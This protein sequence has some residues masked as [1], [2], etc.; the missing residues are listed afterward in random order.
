MKELLLR[1]ADWIASSDHQGTD[2]DKE[3]E[4]LELDLL[5][6][7][8]QCGEPVYVVVQRVSGDGDH[9]ELFIEIEDADGV[10]VTVKSTPYEGDYRRIGPLHLAQP[11]L[12][13]EQI[14]A[15]MSQ[16]QSV[17]VLR[18]QARAG[19]QIMDM[20]AAEIGRVME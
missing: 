18:R 9:E 19:G 7:A 2:Y 13:E 17:G 11:T 8:E 5:A 3:G 15:I 10:S 1:A 4:L 6:A 14:N 20:V 12:S 16:A